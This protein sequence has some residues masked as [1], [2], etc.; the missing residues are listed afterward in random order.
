[1]SF[2]AVII[3]LVGVVI[4]CGVVS[5]TELIYVKAGFLQLPPAAL[6]GLLLLVGARELGRR[7]RRG[8]RWRLDP[9]ELAAIYGMLLIAGLVSSRGLMEKLIPLL[10]APNYFASATNHWRDRFFPQMKPWLVAFDTTGPPAQP[11]VRAYYEGL[12]TG[13]PIPWQAW[14]VP[15][16]AWLLLAGLVLFAFLCLASLFRR[17]WMENERLAFPLT[18]LPLELVRDEEKAPLLRSPL[19]WFGF[20]LPGCVYTMNGL[21]TFYPV[22]PYLQQPYVL[23][24]FLV[25]PPWNAISW[26]PVYISFAAFGLLYL[27]PG[28]LLFSLWFFF[29]LARFEDLIAAT[30]GYQ[31]VGM[32]F[33]P[34]RRFVGYQTMGAYMVLAGYL[35][36]TAAPRLRAAVGTALR[37]KGTTP[38]AE[39]GLLSERVAVGGLLFALIAIAVWCSLAG[40]SFW[41]ALAQWT[42]YLLVVVLVLARSTAEG[43]LM[44]TEVSFRPADLYAMVSPIHHLGPANMT[45]MAFMD[46]AWF[47][48]QRGLVLGGMLDA[49]RVGRGTGL[50]RRA[51]LGALVAALVVSTLCSLLIQMWMPYRGG[52]LSFYSYLSQGNP[53]WGFQYYDGQWNNPPPFGWEGAI[54][55][56]VGVGVTIALVI[57]RGLFPWWPLQPLGYA[58]CG[59]W[60]LILLWF[61]CLL[62]W[63]VKGTLLR[64]GG[65]RAFV[66][67]RP[68]FLGMILGEFS[69]AILWTALS[70]LLQAPPPVFPW[71]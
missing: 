68:F 39:D 31:T 19:M 47:R 38:G 62:I 42:V 71:P 1:L 53:I 29:V 35:L 23:N 11:L 59:S 43:G 6:G 60:T 2:F 44:A 25:D 33:F 66:R 36:H 46:A 63:I 32:P 26:M 61:P 21:H 51:M 30:Y 45:A 7:W 54:F 58:L 70:A 55:F 16:L 14:V 9:H 49:L 27:V 57:L 13:V 4:V 67:L 5:G 22:V 3:G 12:R 15:L 34:C 52:A 50:R 37:P 20:A 69:M 24:Q 10:V 18:Q 8:R 56:A 40:L 64:Y 28:P 17:P 65:M 41:W 48:D